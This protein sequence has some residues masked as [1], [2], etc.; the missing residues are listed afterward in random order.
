MHGARNMQKN[1]KLAVLQL[2]AVTTAG[3]ETEILSSRCY[4][5]SGV[6]KPCGPITGY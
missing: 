4:V 3:E 1:Q 2:L 5:F 6:V